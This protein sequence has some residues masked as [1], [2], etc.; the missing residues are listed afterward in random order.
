VRPHDIELLEDE[1]DG[2]VQALVERVAK[3]GFEVRIEA[4]LGDGTPVPILATR[5]EAYELELRPGQ[6]VWM[7]VHR[8]REFAAATPRPVASIER[9][10]AER[11]L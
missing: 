4:A 11:Q 3:V 7:R 8:A 9:L 2:A 1:Q 10:Q 6:I 5:Q